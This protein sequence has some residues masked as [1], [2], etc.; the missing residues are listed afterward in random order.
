MH[1]HLWL[2]GL[3]GPLLPHLRSGC[4]LPDAGPGVRS[5][6]GGPALG[7]PPP[8]YLGFPAVPTSGS[9]GP[10]PTGTLHAPEEARLPAGQLL[11]PSPAYPAA[12]KRPGAAPCGPQAALEAFDGGIEQAGQRSGLQG[13][14]ACGA[15]RR[16]VSPSGAVP[17]FLRRKDSATLPVCDRRVSYSA[18]HGQTA[19]PVTPKMEATAN[20]RV[21]EVYHGLFAM[22]SRNDQS[23]PPRLLAPHGIGD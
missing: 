20:F 5:L 10:A 11:F 6:P 4:V 1:P 8:G 13:L 12:S 9:G 17:L 21:Q 18:P 16:A 22:A 19:P 3:R 14:R 2:G 23:A 7:P 15:G